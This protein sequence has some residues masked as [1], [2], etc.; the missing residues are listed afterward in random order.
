MYDNGHHHHDRDP[1]EK[2]DW[3][4]IPVGGK[5]L[6]ALNQKSDLKGFVQTI[7]F[8]AILTATGSAAY[9]SIGRLPWYLVIPLF[10]IHGS[11]W[12]F[13][14][15][16]FHELIHDS[17]FKTRWLNGFFLRIF[18]FLGWYNHVQFWASHTEHHKFTLH[19]PDDLEETLP[20]RYNW[21]RTLRYSVINPWWPYN[22]LRGQIRTAFGVIEGDWMH[23]LFDDEPELRRKLKNWARVML[24]GH[25]VIIAVSIYMR[26]WTLPLV[27]T[28]T[29]MYGSPL[30]F[31]TNSAQHAGLRDNV[32]DF[33]LCC[34]TIYLNPLLQFIYWNMNFHTEHHMYA[35]VPCYNLPKLHR[36]I[37]DDMPHCPSGLIETWTQI[38]AIEQ[39][40]KYDPS[41]L[42]TP[43]VPPKRTKGAPTAETLALSATA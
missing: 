28:L 30:H 43:A 3:Y 21:W 32:P 40:Q 4:R 17:V 24:I 38:I 5:T 42:F 16:G 25:G 2:V 29:P 41:Y 37:K 10:L 34:R 6:S 20:K 26:W 39:R 27:T 22:M 11:V 8:L 7:G 9:F 23:H 31:F 13:L 1:G 35:G 12:S 19:P 15:N 18:S 14:I 36:L 33:R